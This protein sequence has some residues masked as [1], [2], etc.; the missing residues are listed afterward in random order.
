MER[1]RVAETEPMPRLVV[2]YTELGC[3]K[4]KKGKEFLEPNFGLGPKPSGLGSGMLLGFA[5]TCVNSSY[6][7]PYVSW[8][9]ERG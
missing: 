7:H 2:G 3:S 5:R 6:S 4:W 8:T 9:A 1:G